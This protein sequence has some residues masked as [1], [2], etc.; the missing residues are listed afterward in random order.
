MTPQR[1]AVTAAWVSFVSSTLIMIVKFV[2]YYTTHSQAVL[3]DAVES[4]IN[5]VAS[6]LA[7][8]VMRA[9]A[10]PADEEHPYGHGKLEYFS[11]AFEGG[12]IAFAA[13]AIAFNAIEAMIRGTQI[14]ELE[15]GMVIVAGAAAL[16]L[17]LGLYLLATGKKFSSEALKAS[18]QHVLT[19]VA[20]S[21]GVFIGLLLVKITGYSWID[22]VVAF[23]MALGLFRSGYKIVRKSIGSLI[24]EK[25]PLALTELAKAFDQYRHL[26]VIDIH[27]VKTIRSGR[28]HHVDAHLVVPEFWDVS[29]AH[30]V[31]ETFEEEVIKTYP[32]DGEIAFHLDP[33]DRMYCRV[34]DFK[35]C[36]VRRHPFEQYRS[37]NPQTLVSGPVKED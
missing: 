24:D 12:L 19:D 18:G 35:N 37:F 28:F 34:C 22:A 6:L 21:A 1:L 25:D 26:G 4:I 14:H 17:V 11:A 13:V 30:K 23:L 8:V 15:I 36:A 2:A 3:S 29:H 27:Q 33:C 10:E 20:T 9:V 32:Y 7:L 5:V 31:M 16:N